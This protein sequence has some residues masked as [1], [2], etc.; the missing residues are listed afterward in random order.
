MLITN[1]GIALEGMALIMWRELVF[2]FERELA[3]IYFS[4][5]STRIRQ[6]VPQIQD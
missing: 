2:R 1:L 6:S 4:S 3:S 5:S